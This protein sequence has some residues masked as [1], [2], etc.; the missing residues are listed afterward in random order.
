[1]FAS[2]AMRRLLTVKTVACTPYER[3]LTALHDR[4]LI[5]FVIFRQLFPRIFERP[6]YRET[7][8]LLN[9][10][11]HVGPCSAN[12]GSMYCVG[13]LRVKRPVV[14]SCTSFFQTTEVARIFPHFLT[15]SSTH[16]AAQRTVLRDV[17]CKIFDGEAPQT[18]MEAYTSIFNWVRWPT[19]FTCVLHINN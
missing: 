17:L 15:M 10:R 18:L 6:W 19:S 13:C 5:L 14:K 12:Y 7:L 1:M 16:S 3:G 9:T 2:D 4:Y 8:E 11:S